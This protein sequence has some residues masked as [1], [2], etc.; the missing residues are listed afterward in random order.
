[1]A[2]NNPGEV[3][4]AIANSIRTL[5]GST[6]SIPFVEMPELVKGAM[7]EDID[8]NGYDGTNWVLPFIEHLNLDGVSNISGMF[9]CIDYYAVTPTHSL[10]LDNFWLTGITVISDL[11]AFSNL[12]SLDLTGW[13][14]LGVTNMSR[15]FYDTK[16]VKVWLPSTFVATSVVDSDKKPFYDTGTE[17]SLEIYTD[18]TDA[19]TQGWG[20]ISSGVVIHYN[21]TYQDFINA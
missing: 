20:T 17:A 14:T 19:A 12:C 6:S 3:L 11:F 21:S 10:N 13:D 16:I 15:M 5:Y 2:Y 7:V 8:L 4:T 18:A 9:S 1:M